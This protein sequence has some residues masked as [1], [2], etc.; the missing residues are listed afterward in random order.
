M[1]TGRQA[2]VLG[3]V[4]SELGVLQTDGRVTLGTQIESVDK[5]VLDLTHKGIIF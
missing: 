4:S 3:R 1:K 2:V 5:R